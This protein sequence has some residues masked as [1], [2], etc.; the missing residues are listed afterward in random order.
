M[1]MMTDTTTAVVVVVEAAATIFAPV[2]ARLFICC[3]SSVLTLALGLVTWIARS[4]DPGEGGTK[5]FSLPLSLTV[6]PLRLSP[7]LY[8][9]AALTSR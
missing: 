9:P 3:I 8:S 6:H 4:S 2:L 1:K 5:G 7:L